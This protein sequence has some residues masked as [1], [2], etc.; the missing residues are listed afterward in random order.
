MIL[1]DLIVF[2]RSLL[3]LSTCP[4]AFGQ[5]GVILWCLIPQALRNTVHSLLLNG[6]PLSLL[7]TSGY[8]YV[9]N[10]LSTTNNWFCCSVTHNFDNGKARI[11]IGY[12]H[13]ILTT[14]YWP[15]K[16]MLSLSQGPRGRSDILSGFALCLLVLAWHGM[17]CLTA[18]S[19][20]A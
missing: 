11:L 2:I 13:K 7:M 18:S 6:G 10:T 14:K 15:Q 12:D 20:V 17:Q 1:A 16:S 5:K 4:L 9:Q 19:T 3:K 8:P